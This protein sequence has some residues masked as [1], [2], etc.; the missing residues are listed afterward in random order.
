M[1]RYKM[2]STFEKPLHGLRIYRMVKNP[3]TG[4]FERCNLQWYKA[5]KGQTFTCSDGTKVKIAY[6]D[7]IQ[8]PTV[9]EYEKFELNKGKRLWWSQGFDPKWYLTPFKTTEINKGY[10]LVQNPGW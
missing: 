1:V 10:G 7:G 9:F 6:K 8:Q 2:K 3:T 5:S 4:K